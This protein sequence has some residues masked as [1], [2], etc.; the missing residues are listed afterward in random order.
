MSKILFFATV[1]GTVVGCGHLP[2]VDYR[3][4]S[5]T[6]PQ[7]ELR[8]EVL[9]FVDEASKAA[10]EIESADSI[11]EWQT[12]YDK[13]KEL[14]NAIPDEGVAKATERECR[15]I[16][17]QMEIAKLAVQ[18]KRVDEKAGGKQCRAVA[19]DIGRLVKAVKSRKVKD[20]V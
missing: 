20:K 12:E 17:D 13:V 11:P 15:E 9:A 7:Q 18:M 3:P 4:A 19:A 14:Y 10:K 8:P 1:L 16:M 2:L 5:S 6:A